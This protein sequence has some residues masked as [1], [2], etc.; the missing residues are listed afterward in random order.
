MLAEL[1]AAG[2]GDWEAIEAGWPLSR[3][4]AMQAHWREVAPPAHV[5]LAALAGFRA[6]SPKRQVDDPEELAAALRAA[7]VLG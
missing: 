6:P 4:R 3:V 1:V 5:S 2:C 7:G